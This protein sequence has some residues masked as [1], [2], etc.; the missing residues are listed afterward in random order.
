MNFGRQVSRTQI[1]SFIYLFLLLSLY[2]AIGCSVGT[3]VLPEAQQREASNEVGPPSAALLEVVEPERL[4][5]NARP[6]Q[7]PAAETRPLSPE[8]SQAR[9]LISRRTGNSATFLT[10][11]G[12]Y[13]T[14]LYPESVHYQDEAGAWQTIDPA[15]Q[16]TVDSFV[17]ERNSLRSRAGLKRAWLSA[18]A[19][20]TAV[21][22]Q[23]TALGVTNEAGFSPLIT[24]LERD[25]PLPRQEKGGRVLQYAAGWSDSTIAEQLVSAPGSLE[26]SLI[27]QARPQV[28]G[29][30]DQLILQAELRLLP[31]TSLW[32]NG[33]LQTAS[34]VTDDGLEIRDAEGE[35]ALVFDPI[36]AYE[37]ADAAISIPGEYALFPAEENHSWTV[38]IRTP[39]SWWA[40]PARRYPALIDPRIRVQ[41]SGGAFGY[42]TAFVS[43]VT[44]QFVGGRMRLGNY[45]QYDEKTRGYVQFNIM[46]S[47]PMNAGPMYIQKA[48]LRVTPAAYWGPAHGYS[49]VYNQTYSFGDGFQVDAD[50][51]YIGACPHDSACNGLDLNNGA[52]PSLIFDTSP[53]SS[54]IGKLPLVVDKHHEAEEQIE[55]QAVN[56]NVYRK[57]PNPVA[58]EID[59]TSDIDGWYTNLYN[60]DTA[61]GPTFMLKLSEGCLSAA[62]YLG[63][64]EK[65]ALKCAAFDIPVGNIELL[66]DYAPLQL[67][68]GHSYFNDQGVPSANADLFGAQ[69]T[70]ATV[71]GVDLQTTHHQYRLGDDPNTKHWRAVAARG[72]HGVAPVFKSGVGLEIWQYP[73]PASGDLPKM[74]PRTNVDGSETQLLFIDEHTAPVPLGDLRAAVTKNKSNEN[75]NAANRNANYR[76]QHAVAFSLTVPLSKPIPIKPAIRSEDLIIMSEFK[77]DY[78]DKLKIKVTFPP[79]APLSVTFLPPRDG[80]SP[81]I[82]HDGEDLPGSDG[83]LSKTYSAPK[84]GQYALAIVNNDRPQYAGEPDPD[85]IEYHANIE[86]LR[87]P[88]YTIPQD[89]HVPKCQAI[90]LPNTNTVTSTLRYVRFATN[91][92][93]YLVVHSP[94]LFTTINN[95]NWCSANE[96]VAAPVVAPVV[97]PEIGE[98]INY[99]GD[100]MVVGQGTICLTGGDQLDEDGLIWDGQLF[101]TADSGVGIAVPEANPAASPR[102]GV[103]RRIMFGKLNYPVKASEDGET[104]MTSEGNFKAKDEN[105]WLNVQ[106]FRQYWS[107]HYTVTEAL[108]STEEMVL[109]GHDQ[110]AVDV[111]ADPVQPPAAVQWTVKWT[112]ASLPDSVPSGKPNYTFTHNITQT[113][114]AQEIPFSGL[115][116]R[117][118]PEQGGKLSI[119]DWKG[120]GG[121]HAY[122]FR[123]KDGRVTAA[124]S[125]GQATR[126]NQVVITPPG[127]RRVPNG[128]YDCKYNG[129]KVSCLDLR[130]SKP[131]EFAWD[132]LYG[133]KNVAAWDLPDLQI[134]GQAGSVLFSLPGRFDAFSA[135]HPTAVNNFSQ[136]FSFDTWGSEVSISEGPCGPGGPITTL[137]EGTGYIALPMIGADGSKPGV[138]QAIAMTFVMCET[139]LHTVQI[140]F[141]PPQPIPVGSSG[142]EVTLLG[143]KV[144][145]GPDSTRITLKVNFQ[146]MDKSTLRNGVGTVTLDT[147]GLFALQ[148]KGELVGQFT[149]DFRLD[150]AWNPLDLLLQGNV[151]YL[152]SDLITGYLYLHAWRGSGWQNKYP[153]IK[154]NDMHFAGTIGGSVRIPKAELIDGPGPLDIPPFNISLSAEISFGEFCT[155][156]QC[157]PPYAWGVAAT[158]NVFGYKVGVYVGEGGPEIILGT[159]GKQLIDQHASSSLYTHLAASPQAGGPVLPGFIQNL[160]I[161]P[162]Q[163]PF[164]GAGLDPSDCGYS[165][166]QI[167][168]TCNFTITAGTGRAMFLA[169]WMNGNLTPVLVDPNNNSYTASDLNAGVVVSTTQSATAT[170]VMFSV[171]PASGQNS[172]EAGL[173]RF[174]LD[175]LGSGK[176]AVA[177]HNFSIAFAVDPPAPTLS[178]TAPLNPGEA[179]DGTYTITWVAGRGGA[180]LENDV[181][182]E[183]FYA[184]VFT[185]QP[186]PQQP[187]AVA[188]PGN[189]VS[190]AGLGDDWDPAASDIMASDDN[191][192]AVWTFT[193][194]AIP[195][196][197]YEYVVA[198][199]GSFEESYGQGGVSLEGLLDGYKIPL[200]V[201]SGTDL[202]T[203]YYDRRDHFIATRPGS[204]IV[205]LIGDMMSA[206]G[207]DDWSPEN[208]AGWMKPSQAGVEL[209]LNLPGGNWEYKVAL[210]ESWDENYGLGGVLDGP[211][212]PL[213]VPVDGT[214]VR[215]TYDETTHLISHTILSETPGVPIDFR[216]DPDDKSYPWNTSGL[217]SGEYL[218]GARIDDI[219]HG[220]GT[221]TAWAPGTILINDTTPPPVPVVV[222]PFKPVTDGLIVSWQPITEALDLAGYQVEYTI[223]RWTLSP[224]E[225]LTRIRRVLPQTGDK[226]YYETVRL[227]GLISSTVQ[228]TPTVQTTVCV[229]AYDASGNLSGCQYVTVPMPTEPVPPLERPD[230]FEVVPEGPHF[231]LS[232]SE[233]PGRVMNYLL[234]YG[235]AGC[236]VAEAI[237]VADEGQSPLLLP[238]SQFEQFLT[239]LTPNQLYWFEVVAIDLYGAEG[240][241][242]RA[243]AM[244]IDSADFD[245]DGMA[246]EWA[247]FYGLSDANADAD[248]DGLNN[249]GEYQAF[250]NPLHADSDGDDFYDGEEVIWGTDI[251]GPDHPPYHWQPKLTLFGSAVNRMRT[252]VNG[253]AV[254]QSLEIVNFGSGEMVWQATA[255]ESWLSL[256]Q[257]DGVGNA[258]LVFTADPS[259]L[260][261]GV[262]MATIT[263][264]TQAASR[265]D[266][267]IAETAEISVV[268]TVMP[269][270]QGDEDL[271]QLYLPVIMRP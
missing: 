260:T 29:T 199:D 170:H 175:G 13:K 80:T 177:D 147:A 249:R 246:D 205:V 231:H 133:E 243:T 229:R 230:N 69:E 228:T 89:K 253:Q 186:M 91:P 60:G 223:P 165:Q 189:Y 178:V 81:R 75:P 113:G 19:G 261:P 190:V 153:W 192:D 78:E 137:V 25:A 64:K 3:P 57:L 26:H 22:W 148:A 126:I 20:K 264:S 258:T 93:R 14:I 132:L 254:S 34:F 61:D 225:M 15:F 172:L 268:F 196:G 106:P 66:I 116:V 72:D 121:P 103:L 21:V 32:A 181:H 201:P 129:A 12:G 235:P 41:R 174:R 191:G 92:D 4:P 227:G 234:R 90:R 256:D 149:A 271:W 245:A 6:L 7:S 110:V 28:T 5:I 242:A 237:V 210:N 38:H 211:N 108:L 51:A 44:N 107:G 270:K 74:L 139:A 151:R 45:F 40:D 102:R 169:G 118:A 105:T 33:K 239:G 152:K 82:F 48:T 156:D 86:I 104:V 77:A 117:I 1:L 183:L 217:A 79:T 9:E 120:F 267:F 162:W 157:T 171:T 62:P 97:T 140:D 128:D 24:P 206:L 238:N 134:S 47:L 36:V 11:E 202:V 8:F 155:N 182:M 71:T 10:P 136:V 114:L 168:Y 257:L 17:V 247:S 233:P 119:I 244:L 65:D 262:Y 188:F 31:G 160:L 240:F 263:I 145:I 194:E 54:P 197:T 94:G 248:A 63:S 83:T 203:F 39:W 46:P 84:T 122:Q 207:G 222:Q 187:G 23:A 130:S 259:T 214:A 193:T 42:G 55:P 266:D 112:V 212:I 68:P 2:L 76:I 56:Q 109:T 53:I 200:T 213:Y 58:T 236:P 265:T 198:V 164:D 255:S 73:L 135:D 43:D 269:K 27:L 167:S 124:Q 161:Y 52:A 131:G 226:Y 220:N 219:A 101:T 150:I 96:N 185:P 146:S 30:P 125:L 98:V 143:G 37:Q 250:A 208:L 95:E 88:K 251:C 49:N 184:P 158:V 154:D 138:D 142:M 252:P 221:L 99:D 141:K 179:A 204:D 216:V 232:W 241:P 87:C 215:F 218:V 176:V 111:L 173:W 115:N 67:M 35:T 18:T 100:W 209:T 180:S 16:P 163:S 166:N 123:A 50:V 85:P 195:T 70:F 159:K 59:V 224:S 127:F 144:L